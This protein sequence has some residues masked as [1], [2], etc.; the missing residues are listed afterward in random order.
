MTIATVMISTIT[1][2]MITMIMLLLISLIMRTTNMI[3]RKPKIVILIH[4]HE[5]DD[6]NTNNDND[7]SSSTLITR[8]PIQG[9]LHPGSRPEKTRLRDNLPSL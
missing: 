2:W 6:S 5:H 7:S 8:I 9:T 3:L 4:D 1:I